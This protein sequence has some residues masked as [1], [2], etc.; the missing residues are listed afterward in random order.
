[1]NHTATTK[2]LALDVHQAT[3][4]CTARAAAGRVLERGVVETSARELVALVCRVGPKLRLT[5]EEGTQ[6]QWL[7]DLLAPHVARLVVCDP[8]ANRGKLA[9]ES[10]RSDAGHLSEL[11]HVGSLRSVIHGGASRAA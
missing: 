7:H 1:M 11:L 5:F 4:K 6:A 9:N 10:A 8:R 2:Y 3:S